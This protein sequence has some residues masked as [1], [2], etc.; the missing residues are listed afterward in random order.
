MGC[1]RLTVERFKQTKPS[2]AD[3]DDGLVETYIDLAQIWAAG[4][5]P[6]RFCEIV[7][8]CVVCHLMTL[9]GQ[10][11]AADAQAFLSGESDMHIIKSG[12]VT[13][14]RFRS[15]AQNAGMSTSDWFG[16]T[17]CG[18]MYLVLLRSVF[19]GPIVV[20]P[21]MGPPVTGYAKDGW[22]SC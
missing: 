20:G 10:G 3:V 15:S 18:R 5:W 17:Q 6:D 21:G 14:S 12:T 13:L 4:E 9:D 22:W 19:S 16:Q 2:F 7:Q 8:V 11:T 1:D